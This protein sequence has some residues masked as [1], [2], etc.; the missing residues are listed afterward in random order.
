MTTV[1]HVTNL[2]ITTSTQTINSDTMFQVESS[3]FPFMDNINA[4][5]INVTSK[6]KLERPDKH[7]IFCQDNSGSMAGSGIEQSK[8]ALKEMVRYLFDVGMDNITLIVYNTDPTTYFFKNKTVDEC[9]RI[10]DNVRSGGGTNFVKTFNCIQSVLT[11]AKNL[12]NVAIIFLTDGQDNSVSNFVD[13]RMLG[14]RLDEL[15]SFITKNTS[16]SEAHTI[17]FTAEH[18][19]KLLQMITNTGTN[20]GTFQYVKSASDIKQC[21]DSVSGLV[22]GVNVSCTLVRNGVETV[23]YMDD[24]SN[25]EINKWST[26]VFI[27]ESDN[28]QL[29]LKCNKLIEIIKLN[30]TVT[31]V[32]QEFEIKTGVKFIND[33][34]MKMMKDINNTR[35][36]INLT[37]MITKLNSFDDKLDELTTKSQKLKSTIRKEVF[38]Q[39]HEI[40]T[41]VADLHNV[42]SSLSSGQLNN[43]K[44]ATLNSL[45]YKNITKRGLQKKLNKRVETNVQLFNDLEK[46]VKEATKS[47]DFNELND[48]YN[49]LIEQVGSCILSCNNFV[50]ALKDEDCLCL[51]FDIGR[52]QAAIADPSRI[53]IKQIYPTIISAESF[54]DSVQYSLKKD[55]NAHGGF[56]KN[57][58]GLIVHGV[59][60]E[61]ITGIMPLYICDENWRVAKYK[62]RPIMGW[63][64]T[65]DVLGYSF[66]QIKTIPFILLATAGLDTSTEFKKWQFNMIKQTC[67]QIYK[68]ASIHEQKLSDEVKTLYGKYLIDPSVRT[69]DVIPNN[70]VFLMQVLCA[71]ENGDIHKPSIDELNL[72]FNH[73]LE[74]EMRRR[75]YNKMISLLDVLNV[76]TERYIDPSVEKFKYEQNNMYSQSYNKEDKY[77]IEQI[78]S[79][80]NGIGV[81][82]QNIQSNKTDQQNNTVKTFD[83]YSSNEYDGSVTLTSAQQDAIK[84]YTKTYVNF[85]AQMN[86]LKK[87]FLE[88]DNVGD[89]TSF[90]SM[91]LSTNEQV[92][93]MYVQNMLQGENALRREAVSTK[94]YYNP[95]TNAI[96]YLKYIYTKTVTDEIKMR[97]ENLKTTLSIQAGSQMTDLFGSTNNVLVAA[98]VLSSWGELHYGYKF[99]ELFQ[100]LQFHKCPLGKEKVKMI[101]TGRY[102]GVR[103]IKGHTGYWNPCR[104]NKRLLM[105]NNNITEGEWSSLYV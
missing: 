92:L 13:H 7:I 32:D 24:N 48:K 67:L 64:T 59:S 87:V 102:M 85:V 77:Y 36:R 82:I 100:T 9:C 44:L 18:D 86:N 51:T 105:E 12:Q 74:E 14:Q 73:V 2:P 52:T 37:D 94:A 6:V 11:K 20:Q 62:M 39:I 45:A 83:I 88:I 75:Q 42:L 40:K 70:N 23:L 25:D 29:V 16:S 80:L 78:A 34:I 95:F 96:D 3:M 103:I 47:I 28:M 5:N 63:I 61:S 66:S 46:K 54:L 27:N 49:D 21:V 15:K 19:V 58:N 38:A 101:L 68:D 97:I 8:N 35:S 81:D 104:R 30:P 56:D 76:N 31:K 10:I 65:L 57:A 4:I 41:T 89:L 26:T 60:R 53:T 98:G 69:I 72:F 79:E 1:E 84:E 71:I 33:Q 43:D 90:T 55:P 22:Q 93:A 91:G 50:E 99:R 17:G